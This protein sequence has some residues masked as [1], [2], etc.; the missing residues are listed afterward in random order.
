M[1][2]SVGHAGE[3]SESSNKTNSLRKSRASGRKLRHFRLQ[4]SECFLKGKIVILSEKQIH[5]YFVNKLSEEMSGGFA[6]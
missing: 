5:T 1:I 2:L 6:C 4:G 3:V